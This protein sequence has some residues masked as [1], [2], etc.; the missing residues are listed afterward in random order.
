M[1]RD[2]RTIIR[3]AVVGVAVAAIFCA[4]F[5]IDSLAES[6]AAAWVSWASLVICPGYFLFIL[7]VAGGELPI[8]DSAIMWVIIGLS[9]CLFYAVVGA[10]SIGMRKPRGGMFKI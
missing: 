8:P 4:F 7:A 5:K 2:W 9:N 6:W 3:F 1:S 10:A